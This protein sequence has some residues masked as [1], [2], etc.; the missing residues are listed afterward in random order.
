MLWILSA[1]VD[2]LCVCIIWIPAFFLLQNRIW[3]GKTGRWKITLFLF[4]SYLAAV[5]SVTGLP[6]VNHM[7]M[8]L[9]VNIIPCADIVSSPWG[10]VLNI[11]LFVPMGFFLPVLW[12]KFWDGKYTVWMGFLTSCAIELLQIFTW[13]ATDIDDLITNTLGT[14]IGWTGTSIWNKVSRKS[15]HIKSE[16][17]GYKEIFPVF[18]IIFFALFL[19]KPYVSDIIWNT[20]LKTIIL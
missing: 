1:V 8:D 6:A 5:G 11:I 17:E 16:S 4:G 10:Y 13:R 7:M 18:I 9:T 14:L 2:V 20:V 3:K 15:L 19:V 12:K